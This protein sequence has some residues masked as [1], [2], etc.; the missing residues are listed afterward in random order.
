[1]YERGISTRGSTWKRSSPSHASPVRYA[2]GMRSSMRRSNSAASARARCG[3]AGVEEGVQP[4]ERKV[5]H[6]QDQIRGF[7]IRVVHA[8]A[9]DELGIAEAGHRPAQPVAQRFELRR[10]VH[11]A[12]RL[13]RARAAGP[14]DVSWRA[15]QALE[16]AAD[17]SRRAL[18]V[19][20]RDVLVQLVDRRVDRAE[21]DDLAA[22]VGDEAAVGR[23]ALG[24]QLGTAAD[25]AF[26]TG[27]GDVDQASARGQE[28][29]A[30]SGPVD[31][32]SMPCRRRI[33]SSRCMSDSR[34]LAV[35]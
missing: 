13:A 35:E 5:E 31:R 9:E 34:V 16:D 25:D 22:D 12:S 18:E 17:R 30:V 28:R 19:G 4:I 7:V 24:G 8:V 3:Q 27:R 1:M 2:A 33:A 32:E 10:R 14:A 23:P 26:D 29:L 21:L 6:M 20:D 11:P 15:E